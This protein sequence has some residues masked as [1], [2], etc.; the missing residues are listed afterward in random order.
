MS[1]IY[2]G[3]ESKAIEDISEFFRNNMPEVFELRPT[4]TLVVP[5]MDNILMEIYVVFTQSF[6]D[7][8][9]SACV[10]LLQGGRQWS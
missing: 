4:S 1:D 9:K 6:I 3:T 5:V 2:D 8:C 7:M 10:V